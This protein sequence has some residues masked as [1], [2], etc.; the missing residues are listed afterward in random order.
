MQATLRMKQDHKNNNYNMF[1]L[2]AYRIKYTE[3]PHAGA[4]WW[5]SSVL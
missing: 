3:H 5:V 1:D 2:I 4:K